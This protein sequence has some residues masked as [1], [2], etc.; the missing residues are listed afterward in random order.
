[1]ESTSMKHQKH[2]EKR[3]NEA[4]QKLDQFLF[5]TPL[6]STPSRLHSSWTGVSPGSSQD[7]AAM[8]A[9]PW[10]RWLRRQANSSVNVAP[11][12]KPPAKTCSE[13][14]CLSI[15][16]VSFDVCTGVYDCLCVFLCFCHIAIVLSLDQNKT[17][18]FSK[19]ICSV[20]HCS[21]ELLSKSLFATVP[22]VSLKLESTGFH[23]VGC[24]YFLTEFC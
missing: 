9:K 3:N 24:L 21:Y 5:S 20:L 2:S 13:G 16:R 10:K 4:N 11:K 7:G 19:Q 23:F 22:I 15:K 8:G 1:M 17:Y 14:F 18:P 6:Q 12:L